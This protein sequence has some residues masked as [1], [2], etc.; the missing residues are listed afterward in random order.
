ME[1]N[2]DYQR[3]FEA[4]RAEYKKTVLSLERQIEDLKMA[5]ALASVEDKVCYHCGC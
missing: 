4:A 1:T 5:L 2:N 3:G